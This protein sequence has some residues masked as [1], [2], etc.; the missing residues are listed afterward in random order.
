[1]SLPIG[2]DRQQQS[3]TEP[4]CRAV[5]L[6]RAT[7]REDL[8]YLTIDE[9]RHERADARRAEASPIEQRLFTTHEA[10]NHARGRCAHRIGVHAN[11]E[12]LGVGRRAASPRH[13]PSVVVAQPTAQRCFGD[14]AFAAF[15]QIAGATVTTA[16]NHFRGH[17]GVT[18]RDGKVEAL[19]L[20]LVPPS[21][22]D[23]VLDGTVGQAVPIGADTQ[24]IRHTGYVVDVTNGPDPIGRLHHKRPLPIRHQKRIVVRPIFVAVARASLTVL[25]QQRRNRLDRLLCGLTAFESQT[26]QV[27]A[28]QPNTA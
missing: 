7:T 8:R 22:S 2:L 5:A 20:L 19:V 4:P 11:T 15:E 12:V 3:L 16:G 6:T 27:H 17:A 10:R 21:C 13:R 9:Q 1:V 28:D 24:M 18:V 25:R 23:G 14:L 26:Y